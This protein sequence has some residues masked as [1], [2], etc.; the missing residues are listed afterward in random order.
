MNPLFAP[1]VIRYGHEKKGSDTKCETET[2]IRENREKE[3]FYMK[4][5]GCGITS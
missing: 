1:Q 3:L 2:V 4:V 5:P